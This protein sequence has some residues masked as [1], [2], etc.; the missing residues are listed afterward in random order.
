MAKC[1]NCVALVQSIE[2]TTRF[3]QIPRACWIQIGSLSVMLSDVLFVMLSGYCP[4]HCRGMSLG[5]R[6]NLGHTEH[7][8]KVLACRDE[9]L[10]A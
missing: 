7:K 6:S 1:M 5:K 10:P 3:L 4:G 8:A 2:T 9:R